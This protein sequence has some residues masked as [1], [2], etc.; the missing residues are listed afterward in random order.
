M[1]TTN[2]ESALAFTASLWKQLQEIVG[3]GQSRAHDLQELAFHI[4]GIQNAI[5]AQSAAREY[6]LLYRLMGDLV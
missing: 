1:L 5:L 3:N 4:H 2:E 6:P